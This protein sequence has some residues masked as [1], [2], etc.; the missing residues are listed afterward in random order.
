MLLTDAVSTD[1]GDG[2]GV[3]FTTIEGVTGVGAGVGVGFVVPQPNSEL[4]SAL[5][6]LPA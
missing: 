1:D 3:G 6:D 2:E 5:V 4:S